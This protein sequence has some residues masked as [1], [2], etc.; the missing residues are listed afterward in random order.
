MMKKEEALRTSE[1]AKVEMAYLK[2]KLEENADQTHDYKRVKSEL[3]MIN[4][5]FIKS[6]QE[7]EFLRQ[8]KQEIVKEREEIRQLFMSSDRQLAVL[9]ASQA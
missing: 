2:R 1:I 8:R 6:Q 9:K 5:S 3:V 4:E 7:V